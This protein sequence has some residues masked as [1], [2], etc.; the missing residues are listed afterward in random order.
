MKL[1]RVD[2]V[3]TTDVA[4]VRERT[5]CRE[6]ADLMIHRKV[7]AV[8]VVDDTGHAIGVVAVSDL[9]PGPVRAPGGRYLHV[10]RKGRA[11]VARDV[12]S[13]SV[14]AALPSLAVGF[15]APPDAA[16]EG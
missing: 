3:M 9:M 16:R 1:W 12:M 10:R 13:R 6:I 4:T 8:P 11:G 5:P 15:A 7:N 2:D 14:V